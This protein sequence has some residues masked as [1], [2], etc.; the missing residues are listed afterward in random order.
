M[1]DFETR[2][3]KKGE[4]IYRQNEYDTCLYEVLYGGVKLYQ[5]Y[6]TPQQILIKE[7]APNSFLGEMEV[8]EARP[9][10]TTAVATEKTELKVIT[11]DDFGALFR[12]KPALVL[13]VM[14]QMSARIR[15]L[16]RLYNDACRVVSEAIEA[17]ES[18]KEKSQKLQKERR[19]LS[20][21]YRDYLRLLGGNLV[22]D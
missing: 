2:V 3:F 11:K 13:S 4:V 22:D 12:E 8:V 5:N 15:E 21:Y 18:G 20:D 1:A 6:G 10:T 7:L 9:R 14:Q 17:E 16:T 19:H